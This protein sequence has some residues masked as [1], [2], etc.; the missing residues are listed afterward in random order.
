MLK[1]LL[2]ITVGLVVGFGTSQVI[3]GRSE[4]S[5]QRLDVSGPQVAPE[6]LILARRVGE[7]ETRLAAEV[8]QRAALAEELALLAEELAS[9][10]QTMAASAE[11]RPGA[12]EQGM[13]RFSGSGRFGNSADRSERRQES[14]VAAGFPPDQAAE[15]LRREGELR[16][17]AMYSRFEAMRETGGQPGS[18]LGA[19]PATSPLRQEL[20]DEAYDRYLYAS[21]QS[22]RV[23]VADVIATSPGAQAGLKAG[24]MVLSYG[25]Q[26]VFDFRELMALTA[27]GQPGEMVAIEVLRDGSQTQLYLPRGPIG[28]VGGRRARVDPSESP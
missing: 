3:H 24:D 9:M 25:G 20:G 12:D 4:S 7:L 6:P 28:M 16:M 18:G 8:E 13:R 2:F 14:L 19:R 26:R 11:A 10:R 1:G 21:G 27:A 22:N 5:E 17:E 15:I 23:R